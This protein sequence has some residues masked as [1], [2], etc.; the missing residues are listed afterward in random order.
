[1]VTWLASRTRRDVPLFA[2][3]LRRLLGTPGPRHRN[4]ARPSISVS[5]VHRKTEVRADGYRPRDDLSMFNG[6]PYQE[7]VEVPEPLFPFLWQYGCPRMA[8]TLLPLLVSL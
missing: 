5:E 7:S 3:L 2:I 4:H 1:M 8:R 6:D